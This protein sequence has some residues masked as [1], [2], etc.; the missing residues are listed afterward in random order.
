MFNL[1]LKVDLFWK[2]KRETSKFLKLTRFEE[3]T[4]VSATPRANGVS[5]RSRLEAMNW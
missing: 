3:H 2:K 5:F 4:G 1:Q